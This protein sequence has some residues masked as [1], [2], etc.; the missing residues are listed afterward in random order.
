M[1]MKLLILMMRGI[2]LKQTPK[3]IIKVRHTARLTQTS[4]AAIVYKNY[5]TWQRWE[6]DDVEMPQALWELFLIK[7]GQIEVSEL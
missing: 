3:N 1:T 7:T 4:A 5:R 6:A 2:M